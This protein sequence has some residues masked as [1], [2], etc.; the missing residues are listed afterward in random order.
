METEN[1]RGSPGTV[2]DPA[3]LIEGGENVA[4]FDLLQRGKV[5]LGEGIQDAVAA[6]RAESLALEGGHGSGHRSDLPV[7]P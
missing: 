5:P 2:D 3:G 1:P 4:A 6:E 7:R